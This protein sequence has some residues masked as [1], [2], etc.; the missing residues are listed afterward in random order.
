MESDSKELLVTPNIVIQE[1]NNITSFC[2]YDDHG[3]LYH[4]TTCPALAAH[5]YIV[6]NLEKRNSEFIKFKIDK[7]IK[8]F[9]VVEF[10]YTMEDLHDVIDAGIDKSTRIFNIKNHELYKKVVSDKRVK[11]LINKIKASNT[12]GNIIKHIV[13]YTNTKKIKGNVWKKYVKC[14]D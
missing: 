6:M 14:S 11:A 4:V 2:F 5:T 7:A 12:M 3:F 9:N 8:N 10:I 13:N 1:Y